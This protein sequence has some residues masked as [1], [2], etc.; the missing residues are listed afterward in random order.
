MSDV[1]TCSLIKSISPFTYQLH[2]SYPIM[3]IIIIINLLYI[4][5]ILHCLKS[6]VSL[7][8][9]ET[10]WHIQVVNHNVFLLNFLNL[11][12]IFVCLRD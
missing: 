7:N 5:Y 11:I 1:D 8:A 10:T 6:S 9:K 3:H 2:I 4:Y 12:L